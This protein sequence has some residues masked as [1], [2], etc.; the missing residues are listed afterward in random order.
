MYKTIFALAT[1]EQ[2][3]ALSII[4]VSGQK[5]K[6]ILKKLTRKKI[7]KDRV[8]TLRSFF[9]P[10]KENIFI[11]DCMVAWLPGPNTYT[12]EDILEIYSHGGK[13]VFESFFNALSSFKDVVY[14]EQ[15]E[16]SKRA[17]INGKINLVEAEAINDL[18]NSQTE[19]QRILALNQFKRGISV[20]LKKWRSM[21]INCMSIIEAS[22]DFSDEEDVPK[23][24]NVQKEL[25]I[26]KKEIINALKNKDCF[27]LIKEGIKVVFT[28]KTNVGK[29]SL[30][31]KIVNKERSIVSNE[32]GT[33]RDIIE[34]KINL[35]GYAVILYDTAGINKT[36]NKIEKEGIN[37][38]LNLI[39]KADL[40]IEVIDNIEDIKENTMKKNWCV[41]NK[42][43]LLKKNE[44]KNSKKLIAVS[45]KTGVGIE[46]LTNMIYLEVK[47]KTKLTKGTETLVSNTRQTKE[48]QEALEAIEQ[49]LNENSIEIIGEYLRSANRSL[50][51]VLGN[52][53]V[54][55]VLGNIF[56][57][58]CIGK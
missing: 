7:P 53:D 45:A 56:S 54:E 50:E 8:L 26:L 14:A 52:I 41:L 4:R 36:K 51:R 20:P 11:D 47:K 38:A 6:Q 23:N 34:N 35:R 25:L 13:T 57:S 58:F 48:L 40:V 5:S 37:R 28:G 10:G 21:L 27:E 43:D 32:P 24:L 46:K 33:T 19:Q 44:L 30:F 12:G 55:E 31:N 18:I 9:Y 29:S 3:S 39:K 22:I 17:M 16:F 2:T 15:G 49:A 42:T 1:G